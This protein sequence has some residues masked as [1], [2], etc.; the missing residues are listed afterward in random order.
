MYLRFFCLLSNLI[1]QFQHNATKSAI[2][3]GYYDQTAKRHPFLG[4]FGYL[5]TVFS[6][7]YNILSREHKVELGL[8]KMAARP[9]RLAFSAEGTPSPAAA[10]ALRFCRNGIWIFDEIVHFSEFTEVAR[11]GELHA[12]MHILVAF[13]PGVR[14]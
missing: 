4:A 1:F 14:L 13:G 9:V 2:R 12:E 3:F 10:L 8:M 7:L 11:S 6:C 5:F